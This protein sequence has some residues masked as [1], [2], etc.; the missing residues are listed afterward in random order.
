M[1]LET[2][3]TLQAYGY[4]LATGFCVLMLYGYIYHLYSSERK[5]TRDYEKYA[6]IALDDKIDSTPIETTSPWD[7]KKNKGEK[8]HV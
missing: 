8:K 1:D 2:L 7:K 5:G 6:N 3:Q 4:V